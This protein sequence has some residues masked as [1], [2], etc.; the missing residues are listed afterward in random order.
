MSANA[1]GADEGQ[2]AWKS[3]TDEKLD[4]A[5]AAKEQ[6]R[7]A[8]EDLE[9][10]HAVKMEAIA[11]ERLRQEKQAAAEAA[12]AKRL[13]EEKVRAEFKRQQ[14]AGLQAKKDAVRQGK[15]DEGNALKAAT[16]SFHA[17][18]RANHLAA[19]R[20]KRIFEMNRSD[21]YLQNSYI[22]CFKQYR[23]W[24]VDEKK[25]EMR[26]EAR[27]KRP[28]SELF[29]DSVQTAL[30]KEA[31]VLKEARADLKNLVDEG[32]KII[33]E[34]AETTFLLKSGSSREN[35]MDRCSKLEATQLMKS[36]SAPSLPDINPKKMPERK[37]SAKDFLG[38]LT[39]NN[40]APSYED[41]LDKAHELTGKAFVLA[42]EC[43]QVLENCRKSCAKAT[44]SSNGALDQRKS[45]IGVL[46]KALEQEK[47][48][49]EGSIKDASM[50]LTMLKMKASHHSPTQEEEDEVQ[51]AE[52][53][54][55]ELQEMKVMLVEDWRCKH[56]AFK[57]DEWCRN[58]TPTRAATL[59][60][61][62]EAPEQSSGFE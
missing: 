29:V 2:S 33:S 4:Q 49:A 36:S 35:V 39:S 37:P 8:L 45:E 41:L 53:M 44:A 19:V 51:A 57:I 21:S 25:C 18:N 10:K 22:A 42:A 43:S 46:R 48:D 50:R 9:Q 59:G 24:Y 38:T 61:G 26:L 30:E 47:L 55:Q 13:Q 32:E 40:S 31:K 11:A 23:M 28:E 58:L 7:K 5:K 52:G 56:A 54:V 15:K 62:K 1:D 20:A 16:A 34:M 14:A 3:K 17:A 12:R 6:V 27:E 60:G